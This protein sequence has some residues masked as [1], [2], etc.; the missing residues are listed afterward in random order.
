[1]IEDVTTA[2]QAFASTGNGLTLTLPGVALL[3]RVSVP[4]A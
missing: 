1:M 2:L 4:N 3:K